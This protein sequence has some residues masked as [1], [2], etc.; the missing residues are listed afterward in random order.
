MKMGK[1]AI[2]PICLVGS[3]AAHVGLL[4]LLSLVVKPETTQD[5]PI[6][7]SRM[8][9][10]TQDVKRTDAQ[11][12][13]ANSEPL[14]EQEPDGATLGQG[15]VPQSRAKATPVAANPIDAV[16]PPTDAIQETFGRN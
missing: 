3:L 11:Q 5:Q 1:H 13:T 9:I 6:P 10:Q 16:T 14:T 2:W 8:S 4:A 15:I 7:K 12:T